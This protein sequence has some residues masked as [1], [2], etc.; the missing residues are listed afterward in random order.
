MQEVTDED[1]VTTRIKISGSELKNHGINAQDVLTNIN[2]K[3]PFVTIFFLDCCRTYHLRN[4][5]LTTRSDSGEGIHPQGFRTMSVGFGSLI[6]YACAPGT[7]ASDG[8]KGEKNG[9][10]TKHLL[11]LLKLVECIK[12]K[13]GS[14]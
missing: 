11:E 8:K 9:L 10:F 12:E 14:L 5:E 13:S 4:D 3:K 7:V 2:K 6:V 1:G